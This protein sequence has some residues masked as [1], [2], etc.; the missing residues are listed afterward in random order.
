MLNTYELVFGT[1][2]VGNVHVVSGRANIFLVTP[3]AKFFVRGVWGSLLFNLR[4]SF[5]PVKI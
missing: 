4:T 3:K 5:L 1:V 2:D